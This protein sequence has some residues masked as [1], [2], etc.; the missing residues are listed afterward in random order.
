MKKDLILFVVFDVVVSSLPMFLRV[1]VVWT[2]SRMPCRC[3][4][5]CWSWLYFVSFSFSF[6]FCH[7]INFEYHVLPSL[8]QEFVFIYFCFTRNVSFDS[9]MILIYAVTISTSRYVQILL[10]R[11]CLSI[12][13]TV[14]SYQGKTRR[15]ANEYTCCVIVMMWWYWF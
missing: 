12:V 8:Q 2:L 4:C 9:R 11:F 1:A 7:I 5:F 3:C 13:L 10:C 14:D 6:C 15:V